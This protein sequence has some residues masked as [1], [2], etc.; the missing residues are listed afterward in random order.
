MADGY[1]FIPRI[2]TMSSALPT[3][4]PGSQRSFDPQRQLSPVLTTMSPVR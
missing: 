3:M 4:P 1:T 2:T